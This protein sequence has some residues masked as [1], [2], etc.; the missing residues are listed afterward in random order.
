MER[1][2]VG[3]KARRR[4]PVILSHGFLVNSRFLNLDSD[5]SLAEY[6]AQ[7]GFDVWNLS[8]RGTG[9]SLNPLRGGPKS[10]TLDDMI[11]EDLSTVIRYVRKESG[12]SKVSWVGYEMGGLLMYGYLEKKG[13]SG[14]ASFVTIGAPAIFNRPEQEPMKRLLKLEENPTL[15]KIF[16]YLDGPFLGRLLLPLL[17]K[18]EKHFY[19][20]ENIEKEIKVKFLETALAPINPGVL[21]HLM[22]MIRKGEFVSAKGDF[23]YRKNLSKVRVPVLLIGGEKDYLAPPKALRT[24]HRALG[25]KDRTLRIF[26]SR[27]K[28]PIKYGHFDL[29]LG[30]KAREEVFPVIGKWLKRRDKR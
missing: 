28:D 16:L 27:S 6:L 7:E 15:R 14:L 10:W 21:D 19:N 1:L 3:K 17:P 26:G 23:S 8:L 30:K 11:G 29:I 25:S 20:P 22:Q 5:H 2:R 4:I 24:T 18:L 12:S 9:R 13:R